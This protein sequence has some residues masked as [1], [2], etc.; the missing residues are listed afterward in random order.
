MFEVDWWGLALPFA[1]I[2]VLLGS[3]ITFS[4]MYRK[5]RAG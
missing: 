1:Y 2:T 5:R 4:S 3:L